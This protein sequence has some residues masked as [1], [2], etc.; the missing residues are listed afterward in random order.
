MHCERD[1]TFYEIARYK[2]DATHHY[3]VLP[4]L[5]ITRQG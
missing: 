4:H 2:G 1:E 5:T 3:V